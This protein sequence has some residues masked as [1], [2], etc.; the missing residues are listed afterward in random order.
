MSLVSHIATLR[1]L[2][3]KR[4]WTHSHIFLF[5]VETT[6]LSWCEIY[7]MKVD[8]VS[9]S[10]CPSVSIPTMMSELTSGGVLTTVSKRSCRTFSRDLL[11]M[12]IHPFDVHLVVV[13]YPVPYS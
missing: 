5:N 4:D 7:I 8:L 6:T 10:K 11:V 1:R 13:S 3:E 2:T 12:I 9:L